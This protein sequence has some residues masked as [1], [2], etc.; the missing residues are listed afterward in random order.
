MD[1]SDQAPPVGAFEVPPAAPEAEH[2]ERVRRGLVLWFAGL[3]VLGAGGLFLR[4][5]ELAGLAAIAGLFVAAHAAD[6][7]ARWKPL[8]YALSWV[9]PAGG[10]MAY[11]AVGGFILQQ[12]EAS[13]L[14]R[15]AA[16]SCFVGAVLLFLTYF[17]PVSNALARFWFHDTSHVLRLAARFAALCLLVG[18]PGWLIMHDL[19]SEAGLDLGDLMKGAG[20]A[21]E[22]LGYVV[23]AFGAV[24]FLVPRDLRQTLDRLGLRGLSASDLIA[25]GVGLLVLIVLNVGAERVQQHFFPELWASDQAAVK[26]IAGQLTVAQSLMLGLSAGIGEEITM[27]GALQ[28]RLGIVWTSLL[29]AALHVQYSWFGMIIVLM[30]GCALGVLRQRTNTTSAMVVHVVFDLIGVLAI[31]LEPR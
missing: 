20:F 25:C 17:R 6:L 16:V 22:L 9:V 26:A 5:T 2:I 10:A 12:G 4:Q 21:G 18:L 29:F 19:M 28:P 31:Q 13:P 27:R 1:T 23:L 30:I 8:H 24:G 15:V 3:V 7:D 11:V 14:H